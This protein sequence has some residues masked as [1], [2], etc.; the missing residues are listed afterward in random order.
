MALKATSLRTVMISN[1]TPIASLSAYFRK[2]HELIM[3]KITNK[4]LTH[5]NN[6]NTFLVMTLRVY[7]NSIVHS[8]IVLSE[9]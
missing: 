6:E 8:V 3:G 7:S 9:L 2:Y 1:D 4:P 5:K